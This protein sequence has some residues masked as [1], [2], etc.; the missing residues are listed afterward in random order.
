MNS[1]NSSI[2]KTIKKIYTFFGEMAP[3]TATKILFKKY[4]GYKLNLDNPLTLNEKMQ[5]LKLRVYKDEP[6]VTQC[7]DKYAVRSY[8]EKC[9]CSDTLI[10]LLGVWDKAED[11]DFEQLPDKFV[12]KCNHGSGTNIIC[13][14]KSEL[15]IGNARKLLNEWL[16]ADFGKQRVEM[17]YEKIDR[18]II[19]ESYIETEDKKPPKDYKIFCAYGEPKFLFV[20]S[21]RFD[22]RT[23]FDYFSINWEW[24]PVENGHPNAGADA[25]P[26]PKGYKEMLDY[27]R[28]LS[29]PFP[30]VRVDFYYENGKVIFGELTFLHFGGL[31]PF[32]PNIFDR[33][34]GDMID[35]DIKQGV[36]K[37][38]M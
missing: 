29:K 2:K 10:P 32:K 18:K 9:G 17:S 25:L 11:I 33:T 3:E 22:N 20:A 38:N 14:N 31:V 21:E 34:F 36:L 26:C 30:L 27:A 5:Y 6:L 16:E 37:E 24:I 8:V 7:A 35:V 15:D 23:K 28:K 1:L 13:T 12:L 19:A 4:L